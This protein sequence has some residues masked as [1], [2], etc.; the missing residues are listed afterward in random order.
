WVLDTNGCITSQT[1][2]IAQPAAA[3]NASLTSQTNVD[4]FGNS[5]GSIDVTAADGT[6]P[7]QF[8]LDGVVFQS[9]GTFT[10]LA[11]GPYTVTVMDSNGCITTVSV[12]M[13]QPFAALTSQIP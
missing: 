11:A 8:S 4:C 7:Y 1:V 2:N 9:S 3:L 13:G 6:P 5:T 12:T 10:G